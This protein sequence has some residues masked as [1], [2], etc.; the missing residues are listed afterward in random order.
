[1]SMLQMTGQLVNVFERPKGVGKNGEEFEAKPT[2]QIMGSNPLQNGQERFELVTLGVEDERPY[3]V[4]KGK[5][6]RVS[7]GVFAT[8]GAAVF[9]VPK[10][11]R[12]DLVTD[13][14]SAQPGAGTA[15][16]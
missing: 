2:I 1:M 15:Q 14:R 7:V 5:Q 16:G 8:K 10:G 3:Q 13:A 4:L 9:Y 6:I 11:S 12:P